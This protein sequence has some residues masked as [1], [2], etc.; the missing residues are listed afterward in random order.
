MI[1]FTKKGYADDLGLGYFFSH[2]WKKYNQRPYLDASYWMRFDDWLKDNEILLDRK[3]D[4]VYFK[5]PEHKTMFL[6]T[7]PPL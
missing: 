7:Y 5:S 2:E 4:T 6:L 3:A 1:E